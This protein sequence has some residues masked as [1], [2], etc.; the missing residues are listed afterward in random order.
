MNSSAVSAILATISILEQITPHLLADESFTIGSRTAS[1]RAWR[2]S[3]V[4][5][6]FAPSTM[7]L[8]VGVPSGRSISRQFDALTVEGRPPAGTNASAHTRAYM[9]LRFAAPSGVS[10]IERSPSGPKV[11]RSNAERGKLACTSRKSSSM[12]SPRGSS[13]HPLPSAIPTTRTIE[14]YSRWRIF[15]MLPATSPSGPPVSL[16][17]HGC[18]V[19]SI[20]KDRSPE[21]RKTA[22]PSG[23]TPYTLWLMPA[24]GF[25]DMNAAA[26]GYPRFAACATTQLISVGVMFSS[27]PK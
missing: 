8:D 18:A 10:A 23:V 7:I 1:K 2:A 19:G 5:K 27:G 15:N 22:T 17:V 4:R 13:A 6:R 11:T 9:V 21:S 14:P 12:L 24:S 16:I 3:A 26:R 25:D 20:P